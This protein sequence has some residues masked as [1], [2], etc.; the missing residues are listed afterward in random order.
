MVLHFYKAKRSI[1]KSASLFLACLCISASAYSQN[2]KSITF[3]LGDVLNSIGSTTQ[4]ND[5]GTASQ[6]SGSTN[7]LIPRDIPNQ[8]TPENALAIGSN[9]VL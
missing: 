1:L 2:S 4:K 5:D 6:G 7:Q 3:N 8:W 9:H